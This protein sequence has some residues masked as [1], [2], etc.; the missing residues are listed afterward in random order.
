MNRLKLVMPR[1]EL[2]ML[3]CGEACGN[4]DTLMWKNSKDDMIELMCAS[5]CEASKEL[6]SKLPTDS[7]RASGQLV[8]LRE[9]NRSD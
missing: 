1:T 9:R 3:A 2:D 5:P 6:V 8:D 4:I 7:T